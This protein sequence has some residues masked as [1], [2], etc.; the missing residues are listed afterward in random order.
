MLG[1]GTVRQQAGRAARE[2]NKLSPVTLK[3]REATICIQTAD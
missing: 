1:K 3:H 2:G